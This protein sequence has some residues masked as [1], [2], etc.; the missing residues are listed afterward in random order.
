MRLS[1]H[2]AI[3]IGAMCAGLFAATCASLPSLDERTCGNMVVEAFEECD[4][5]AREAGT[6]CAK[7][8]EDHACRFTCD[9]PHKCP[10][11][12]ECGRDRV[13]RQPS[14][15]F[16]LAEQGERFVSPGR[17][18]IADFNVDDRPDVLV[19][20]QADSYG[21]RPA[22]LVYPSQ[23]APPTGS[24]V[25][26]AVLGPPAIGD[27]ERSDGGVDDLAFADMGGVALLFGRPNQSPEFAMFPTLILPEHTHSRGLLAEV[28]PEWPGDEVVTLV[29]RGEGGATI[30]TPMFADYNAVLTHLPAG[31][32]QIVGPM[33]AGRFDESAPCASLV[34]A[35]KEPREVLVFELCRAGPNGTE[36]NV[37]G[38]P[39][40]VTLPEGVVI[41]HG[42]Q[43]VDLDHDGHL[44]LLIGAN[45]GTHVAW[46]V[47]DGSFVSNKVGGAPNEAALY[48]LPP[49]AGVDLSH[50]LAV[51]DLNGDDLSDFVFPGRVV[52][53]GGPEGHFVTFQNLGVAWTEAVI[54]DF[55]GN[56]L[57]DIAATSSEARDIDFLNN[58]GGG[59]L[60]YA[61]L[62][63]EG[64]VSHLAV[65]DF[66]GDLLQDLVF[67][68]MTKTYD[69]TEEHISLAFGSPFGPP[70]GMVSLG[71]RDHIEQITTGKLLNVSGLDAIDEIL[72][73]SDDSDR[74]SFIWFTGRSSRSIYAPFPLGQGKWPPALP[75]ALAFGSFG[76]STPDIA[77]LG[78]D[79]NTGELQL[80]RVE[81]LDDGP[82]M[83][84]SSAP[85]SKH[86]H[87][88]D[89]MELDK[90]P[91]NFR[92]GAVMAAAD[93][94]GDAIDE[95]VVIAPYGHAWDGAA[96]VI[97][98]YDP[99]KAQFIP[100]PEREVSVVLSVDATLSLFDVDGDDDVDA[101]L[102][103]GT[104]E[105]PGPLVIF[106]G[107]GKGD[108]LVDEPTEVMP[109]GQGVRS[110]ACMPSGSGKPCK[111]LLACPDAT[112]SLAA[113]A[114][115]TPEVS[116]VR[117]LPPARALGVAD[118][119]GDGL[120]DIAVLTEEG[121][122][123]YRSMPE[124]P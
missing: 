39:F 19:L 97:A 9:G 58:A 116:L 69:D 52:M 41:D 34:L 73:T 11:G 70:T 43:V 100:R 76:D 95:V 81:G 75:I 3:V 112:H 94:D 51:A 86:F 106:W 122:D 92:Y 111:L 80:F 37:G 68:Q 64:L 23:P 118:F 82:E 55:N 109:D 60:N 89:V 47:G 101:I 91:P 93:L 103:T 17:L 56:G 22:R 90:G 78:V 88:A 5:H 124:M 30:D 121:L 16:I 40:F 115:R 28:L 123:I 61:R 31:L 10:A 110:V 96:M 119:N 74:D 48:P 38:A 54:A 62:S 21:R 59:L 44:D 7:D 71:H 72:A 77:A 15:H 24:Q 6:Y 49:S 87:H 114:E 42:V 105:E 107:N 2:L 120:D 50:P 32:A 45:V 36:W 117:S 13:C 83:P 104:A 53:S 98:D 46:G 57:L 84:L 35:Y 66:D 12:Y 25:I 29:D 102:T 63:T 108:F 4:G 26:P 99:E 85:F 20:G 8:G 27:V 67:E 79:P 33:A 65:G 18:H 14:G 113:G 1:R